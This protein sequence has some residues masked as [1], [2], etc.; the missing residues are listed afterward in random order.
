M[1][2]A[3]Y[4]EKI[5]AGLEE[6]VPVNVRLRTLYA[7]VQDNKRE[8]KELLRELAELRQVIRKALDG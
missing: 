7:G 1:G 8:L 2:E 6:R 3:S 5:E 4:R